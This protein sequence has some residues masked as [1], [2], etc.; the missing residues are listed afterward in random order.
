MSK[1][2]IPTAPVP[3]F[4]LPGV[5]LFPHQ[6]LPLHVFEE[7]YRD[8]VRDL[9]DAPGRFVVATILVGEQETPDH[10][11]AVLPV[12]GYGEI[13]RH[14]KLP[15]GRYLIWVVGLA[16]VRIREV[17]SESRYRQVYCEP[18]VEQQ[19]GEQEAEVL[20]HQLHAAAKARIKGPLPLPPSTAPDLLADLLVQTLGASQEVLERV[21]T[22]PSVSTR[23]RIVLDAA[24]ESGENANPD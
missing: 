18:F 16:R 13:V 1:T 11:P 4:P 14:E 20:T 24:G 17:A 3:M 22:E 21:F 7:R 19:P 12:A 9:L 2:Q 5:F 15:D 23:A 10:R 6:V 8:L